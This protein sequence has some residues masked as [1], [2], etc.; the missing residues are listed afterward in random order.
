MHAQLEAQVASHRATED[1]LR[2]A[3]QGAEDTA[4][5]ETE[6]L[7]AR[8]A[9]ADRHNASLAQTLAALQQK[10][11]NAPAAAAAVT[12]V[13]LAAEPAAAP[14]LTTSPPRGPTS[15]S[16][17]APSAAP[18]PAPTRR[19]IQ[20]AAGLQGGTGGALAL[21]GLSRPGSPTVPSAPLSRESSRSSLVS[22][23][24][25]AEA[26]DRDAS[27]LAAKW[28][29]ARDRVAM[30]QHELAEAQRRH[31]HE[32]A[33][34]KETIHAL[35]QEI[36]AAQG[37]AASSDAGGV[38]RGMKRS[39]TPNRLHFDLDAYDELVDSITKLEEAEAR[40]G[41]LEQENR[42]LRLELRAPVRPQLG[43]AGGSPGAESSSGAGGGS[44]FGFGGS[45]QV[46]FADQALHAESDDVLG[47]REEVQ[48]PGASLLQSHPPTPSTPNPTPY[49][50]AFERGRGQMDSVA[51][52]QTSESI[53]ALRRENSAL[54]A[55]LEA[56]L[57]SMG[58]GESLSGSLTSRAPRDGSP[59]TPESGSHAQLQDD[60]AR[61]FSL[62]GSPAATAEE[63]AQ[64]DTFSRFVDVDLR[65]H[66]SSQTEVHP[67]R[68]QT[69]TQQVPSSV[70][71]E[72]QTD[73]AA[74]PFASDAARLDEDRGNIDL[75]EPSLRSR[76]F[77]LEAALA[78]KQH[79][80]DEA[81]AALSAAHRLQAEF[82]QSLASLQ[83]AHARLQVELE[84][85]RRQLLEAEVCRAEDLRIAHDVLQ[86]ARREATHPASPRLQPLPTPTPTPRGADRES[87]I[88]ALDVRTPGH[89][90]QTVA[91]EPASMTATQGLAICRPGSP[92]EV[93]SSRGPMG[94]GASAASRT[95]ST[96]TE[97]ALLQ[98]S[99]R[100]VTEQLSSALSEQA[101]TS[102]E[103]ELLRVELA[104]SRHQEK[105]LEA[106]LEEHAAQARR[107]IM[108]LRASSGR[109]PS[110]LP[111][112]PGSAMQRPAGGLL[113]MFSSA[114]GANGS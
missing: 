40:I 59:R 54:K 87:E 21:A 49:G 56:L 53:A 66:G 47:P 63:Q 91:P 81:H 28:K 24:L 4:R 41:A 3:L 58:T 69:S 84:D 27:A 65:N 85:V 103:T 18:S 33:D 110:Q 30:L 5:V 74:L 1:A 10:L 82:Q 12:G 17:A 48:H 109:V 80:L 16:A 32:V 114:Y 86:Q 37:A 107:Q 71:E 99:L 98:A 26:A 34:L 25:Q 73:D 111:P 105:Q 8:I 96:E 102:V 79:E 72:S 101:K 52:E 38:I 14:I 75:E 44:G 43:G 113:A 42:E 68:L 77:A 76:V 36:Q 83:D 51:S 67:V 88:E 9:D 97:R 11:P 7:R 64:D 62:G 46:R 95:S 55:K 50:F 45:K 35:S 92:E 106:L 100:D 61:R 19:S 89:D 22:L 112:A 90:G 31:D 20:K 15:T 78:A 60:P 29:E 39:F 6:A 70:D 13:A 108:T 57:S 23:S 94:P 104:K 2:R 93:A